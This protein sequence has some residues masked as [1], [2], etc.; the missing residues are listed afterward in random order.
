MT[1]NLQVPDVAHAQTAQATETIIV[2]DV[3]ATY[4][5]RSQ[6]GGTGVAN[7]RARL[8]GTMNEVRALRG[9]SFTAHQG[10][11]IAIVGRNGAGKSTLLR[12]IAG[13]QKPTA[14]EVLAIEHP[15]L[16]GVDAALLPQISGA[17]NITLGC[18]AL[19]M[20][21]E[22]VEEIRP[23]I[24]EMSGVKD[25]IHNPLNTY[26][27]GMRA[28]LRFAISTARTPRLLMVDEALATGDEVFRGRSNDRIKSVLD[29][30]GTVLIVSHSM[31]SIQSMCSRG[32][33]LHEGQVRMDGPIL[34]VSE[35]YRAWALAEDK[36]Q[37]KLAK[38][39]A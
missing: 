35:S 22:E 7:W 19:G 32:I 23:S 27:S 21:P 12:I 1:E 5:V 37:R 18:L 4:K 15:T 10:E 38:E 36:R 16:L 24:V 28:R 30:A 8:V 13:L 34:E 14:G 2:R 25:F 11:S 20:T 26:S 39:R 6:R 17:R 9:V 31:A 33:W 29:S 3:V